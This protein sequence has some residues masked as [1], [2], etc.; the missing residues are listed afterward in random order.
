MRI[1]QTTTTRSLYNWRYISG[2]IKYSSYYCAKSAN[3]G[4]L[5]VGVNGELLEEVV[6]EW[7]Q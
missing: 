7:M 2:N 6:D 5:N 1:T 3:V 4:R